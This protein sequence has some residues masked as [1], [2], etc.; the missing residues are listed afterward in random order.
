MLLEN[1]L[2]TLEKLN[3]LG[4]QTLVSEFFTS[5]IND[6]GCFERGQEPDHWKSSI[7]P[8][9]CCRKRMWVKGRGEEPE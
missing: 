2:V 4:I 6:V 9:V 3:L 7:L 8:W 1:Q 5:N